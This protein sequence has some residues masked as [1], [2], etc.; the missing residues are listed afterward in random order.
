MFRKILNTVGLISL[1]ILIVI[2]VAYAYAFWLWQPSVA[3][4][5]F[6]SVENHLV[7]KLNRATTNKKLGSASMVLVQDGKVAARHGFGVANAETNAPVKTDQTLYQMASVSKAV[8]AWGVMNLV[9]DGKVGLD[10]PV[11]RYLKRWQF[12][13]S[14]RYHDKV[15]VRHLLSHTAGLDDGLGFPGFLAGEKIQTLE[16]ALTIT[17]GSSVGKP[18]PVTVTKEPGMGMSYGN[19]NYAILQLLIEEV[20]QRSFSDYMKEAVLLPLGM[21][22]ASFDLDALISE[23][24]EQDLAP[25]FDS[26]LNPQPRHRYTATAAVALYASSEDMARFIRAFSGTNPVLTQETL[27]QMMTPQKGT[28]GTWGLG[29]NLFTE[30]N[31]GGYVI[32]HDG[33]AYPS[34]GTMV[35]MNPATKNGFVLMVSGANGSVNQLAHDWVYWETGKITSQARRQTFYD[36]LKPG[37]FGIVLGAIAIILW[38][39]VRPSNARKIPPKK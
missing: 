27:T 1:W 22:K 7:Q 2:F 17:K 36:T 13:G 19:G 20:T 6:K 4:G 9:E 15:T 26:R 28:Y 37:F 29:V 14:K 25:N 10:E 34:W 8:T 24:R 3:R 18:R 12:A 30:N 21:T 23:G 5:N 38:S 31:A 11:I 32:G 33:G 35:R 16:E 39:V